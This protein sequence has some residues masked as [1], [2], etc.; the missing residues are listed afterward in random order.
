[1]ITADATCPSRKANILQKLKPKE[2]S[3]TDNW[4][5]AQQNSLGSDERSLDSHAGIRPHRISALFSQ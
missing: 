3:D 5:Q 1:M 4:I 2:T